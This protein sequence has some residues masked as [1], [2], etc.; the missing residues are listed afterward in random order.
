MRALQRAAEQGWR[1]VW[2]A[3]RQPYFASLRPRADFRALLQRVRA[4]NEADARALAPEATATPL[5]R[6]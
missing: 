6:S 1:E 2:L 4:N 5:P 3:E